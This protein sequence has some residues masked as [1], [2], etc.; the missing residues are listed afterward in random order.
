MITTKK[1][2]KSILPVIEETADKYSRGHLFVIAGSYGMA[3]AAI[4]CIRAAFAAGVGYVTAAMPESIYPI[5]TAAVPEAV[6][7]PYDPANMQEAE[8]RFEKVFERCDA[9][10]FGPG[11][12]TLR[13]TLAPIV[14]S[15]VKK[16]LLID[17][18]GLNALALLRQGLTEQEI[19]S[20]FFASCDVVLTPHEGECGRLL[21]RDRA[22]VHE[23]RAEAAKQLSAEF[24]STALLKGPKTLIFDVLKGLEAENPTGCAALARAGS[25]DVLSGVIGSLMAQ[26]VRGFDAA[27]AGA[28]IHGLAGEKCRETIGVR[29]TM[30]GDLINALKKTDSFL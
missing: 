5:V 8:S 30:P 11:I 16:P 25:G 14:F 28:Y 24:S 26:G 21:G 6:C 1:Y 10:V 9:V 20:G 7:L 23:N 13:D 29:S 17:A 2:V 27:A 18:D 15:K 3:G 19:P 4:L 12:G 22:Y